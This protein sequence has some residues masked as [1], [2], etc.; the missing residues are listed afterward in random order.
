MSSTQDYWSAHKPSWVAFPENPYPPYTQGAEE[1]WYQTHW[2]PFWSALGV[3]ERE[4]YLAHWQATDEQR[5]LLLADT[6]LHTM[7]DAEREVDYI[8]SMACSTNIKS[9]TWRQRLQSLFKN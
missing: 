7:S 8:E 6:K 3:S 4:Q 5:R 1:E 2:L 9:K